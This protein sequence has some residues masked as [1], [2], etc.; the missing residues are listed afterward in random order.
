MADTLDPDGSTTFEAEID[1]LLEVERFEPSEEFRRAASTTD[2]SVYE[3]AERDWQGYWARRAR[4]LHWHEPFQTVLDDANPPFYRWF[5]DGRIN[6]SYNCVDR[7]VEAGDGERVAYH[8]V[9]EEGESRTITYADLHRD[10]QRF[11]NVLKG[12]GVGTGDVV[13]IFLPMIPEVVV[14]MLAC[15]RIGATHNVVFGGFA[16]SSV[17]ERMEVSD[18]KVLVTVDGARRKGRTAPVK[19][20]VDEVIDRAPSVQHVLVV[21]NAG[22]DCPMAQGRDLFYDEVAGTVEAECPAEP[23]DPET[24]LFILYSSGST[25]KPKGILHTSGGY[26]TGVAATTKDVFDLKPETDV[27]WCTAD[28]GWVTGHSYIVYGPLANG[29]T[30][31]MFEGAP[32]YPHKG[33]WWE[34]VERFGV[35]I[36]YTAPTAIRACIKWGPEHPAK[37]DLSSLRLLGSVGEPINPKA[38]VWYYK[39]IGGERCPVVDTWW[40]TETGAVMISPLPGVTAAKPGSATRPIPGISAKLVDPDTGQE[41]L[42]GEGLLAIDRPWPSMLRTLYQD[43][44]RYVST[45]W[46][47]FGPRTYVAG[48]GARRDA[49]GYFTIIGRIDDVINVSGHRLSTAEVE[50]AIVAHDEVAEAAVVPEPHDLTGQAIVAF[51][52]LTGQR[53]GDDALAVELR[54]FVGA[55]IGKLARPGRVVFTDDLPKTRSGK[56][57]RRLLRDLAEGRE[58]GDVTTLRD[59]SVV[60]DLRARVAAQKASS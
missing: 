18:A 42:E 24:P 4:E 54:E 3:E 43:D 52:T 8:W 20:A 2:E 16:P 41:V 36:F 53:Q 15:A 34:L 25:A 56:I 60:D 10:V 13:G 19:A 57:M 14:A 17:A 27:Y 1:A 33:I 44:E 58:L 51:V 55:R 9:G 21:R 31:V 22:V 6:V 47:R 30:S 28:V 39:V 12:L 32:D 50:S 37:H 11:A 49:D 38:W 40:Q 59:P 35:T 7:H 5:T 48:D 45:Y 29:A 46:S 26:L 23:L